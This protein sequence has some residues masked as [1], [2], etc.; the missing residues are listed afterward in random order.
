MT[1]SRCW[2]CKGS[3]SQ[4]WLVE[5]REEATHETLVLAVDVIVLVDPGTQPSGR[6]KK[7]QLTAEVELVVEVVA[8]VV[9]LR[10]EEGQRPIE[11]TKR[12]RGRAATNVDVV[13]GAVVRPEEVVEGLREGRTRVRAKSR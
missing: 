10:V 6:P 7:M 11:E 5:T 9:E 2:I 1:N 3:E 8:D 4:R 13:G 12:E